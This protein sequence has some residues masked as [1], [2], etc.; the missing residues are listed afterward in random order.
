MGR[1]STLVFHPA[2]DAS[3]E[4]FMTQLKPCFQVSFIFEVFYWLR[5]S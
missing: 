5:Q 2:L 4:N 1:P 3:G